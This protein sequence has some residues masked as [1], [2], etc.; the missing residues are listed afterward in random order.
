MKDW[1][2]LI[3]D[4]QPYRSVTPLMLYEYHGDGEVDLLCSGDIRD[5]GEFL[6]NILNDICIVWY[7]RD[8][9]SLLP[10][11]NNYI[12]KDLLPKAEQKGAASWYRDFNFYLRPEQRKTFIDYWKDTKPARYVDSMEY[13]IQIN[14]EALFD[15]LFVKKGEEK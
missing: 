5:I 8:S 4:F 3:L 12:L 13:Q 7:E 6:K 10:L 11:F 9:Y 2:E 14:S 1:K 15:K